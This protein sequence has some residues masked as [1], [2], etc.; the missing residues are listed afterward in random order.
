VYI[1]SFL[2]VHLFKLELHFP[3]FLSLHS[4]RW[5]WVID[6]FRIWFAKW[7]ISSSHI[8][9]IFRPLGRPHTWSWICS[10]ILEWTQLDI[11]CSHWT[12]PWLLLLGQMHVQLN[13]EECLPLLWVTGIHE[14]R[15]WGCKRLTRALA[16]CWPLLLHDHL[17]S[18]ISC[19]HSYAR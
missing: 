18:W 12:L 7:K 16:C 8:A 14:D 2:C 9:F 10:V 19:S 6:T 11:L 13:D 4:S 1:L 3:E 17:S 15:G 5:A